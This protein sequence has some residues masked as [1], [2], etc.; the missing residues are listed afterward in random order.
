MIS[1]ANR[2]LKSRIVTTTVK[3]T[4]RREILDERERKIE[5][6]EGA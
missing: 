5:R 1:Q 4:E 2:M 6:K 3:I